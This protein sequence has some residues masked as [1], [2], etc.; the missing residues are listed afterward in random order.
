M[1]SLL[2]HRFLFRYL[3]PVRYDRKLPKAGKKLLALSSE[4]ALADFGSL[5]N[6]GPFGE[7]RLAWNERGVGV[8]VEVKGKKLRPQCRPQTPESSDGLRIFI[9][10][11]NTQNIH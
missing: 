2:P 3:L 10:T 5:D 4:F 1:S 9:D 8:A 6:A 11:R 7:L